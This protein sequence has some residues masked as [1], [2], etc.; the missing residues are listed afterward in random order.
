MIGRRVEDCPGRELGKFVKPSCTAV[1]RG[2]RPPPD[3]YSDRG[4]ERHYLSFFDVVKS[5]VCPPRVAHDVRGFSSHLFGI[6]VP[7]HLFPNV[8]QKKFQVTPAIVIDCYWAY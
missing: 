7:W 8:T 5:H 4:A 2:V 1:P 3:H 6:C